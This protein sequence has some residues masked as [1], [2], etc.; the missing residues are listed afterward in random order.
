MAADGRS[1]LLHQARSWSATV[2]ARTTAAA[3][4]VVA[5]VLVLGAVALV[6]SLRG[7]LTREVHAA[8][9]QQTA[10]VVRQ[11]ESGA[12][13]AEVVAG[14]SE[15]AFS[16][17]LDADGRV[18]AADDIVVG[19]PPVAVLQP[20]ETGRASVAFDDD[21][22][23]VAAADAHTADGEVIVL[24]A[25]SLDRIGESTSALTGLLAVGVPLV[26]LV[27]GAVTWRIVGHA[28]APVEA[29]RR[30]VDEIS[31]AELH[32]RV[33]EP[34][35]ADEIARLAAT[36]N[37]MLD[38]LERAQNQQRRF[39]S[40]ASHELRSPITVIR[41]HA[42]V[43]LAHPDR[44]SPRDL[45]T[46]VRAES[47]RLQLLVDD[48]LLLARADEGTL[49]LQPRPMDLDDVVFDEAKRLRSM[50]DLHI[51]TAD[52]S[53]GRIDADPAAIRRVLRNL[54][55]NAARHAR[56]TVALHLAEDNGQ[57]VLDVDDDGP[58][59]AT[60][61]RARVLDRFVRLDDARTRDTGGAGLGLAIAAELV[62]AHGGVI[63][64]DASP[65]GGARVRLRFP[66]AD[67]VRGGGPP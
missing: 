48:L 66:V 8:A 33:P 60:R 16:Q 10:D 35:Q 62:A 47:M 4:L 17:L 56:G 43:A 36:M 34:E 58:G 53:A 2:R 50:T 3:V 37:R 21:D 5:V 42:E 45:A 51:D 9:E 14:G 61:D 13:P 67:D 1:G 54:T 22:F 59:I 18:L 31:A 44:I 55:D 64:I 39:V 38:R 63:T 46:T 23:L 11:L 6:L 28:L 7:V 20:G 12:A 26:L 57:V 15:E 29:V 65:T 49:A 27:L 40:D 24:A 19:E 25:R 32:R 30:E 41:Q 52:I